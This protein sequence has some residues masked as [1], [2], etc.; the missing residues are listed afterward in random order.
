MHHKGAETAARVPYDFVIW[1]HTIA[2]CSCCEAS[3][4]TIPSPHPLKYTIPASSFKPR[5]RPLNPC[6]RIE[7]Y[8][9]CKR[10]LLQRQK[11]PTIEAKETSQLSHTHRD[12]NAGIH[13]SVLTSQR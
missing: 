9:R 5:H 10:D 1:V 11:R 7:I 12:L 3:G 6:T 13:V 4:S 8:Y 2:A